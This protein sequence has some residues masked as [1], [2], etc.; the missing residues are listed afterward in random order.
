VKGFITDYFIPGSKRIDLI[1][2]IRPLA[3]LSRQVFTAGGSIMKITAKR[4]VEKYGKL[5]EVRAFLLKRGHH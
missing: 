3:L 5:K 2:R 4:L 1:G